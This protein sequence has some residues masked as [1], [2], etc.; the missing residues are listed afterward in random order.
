MLQPMLPGG[1]LSGGTV[2]GEAGIVSEKR[3]PIIMIGLGGHARVVAELIA[4]LELPLVGVCGPEPEKDFPEF[5]GLPRVADDELPQRFPAA[6][7]GLALGIGGGSRP[8]GRRDIHQRLSGL[9]YD[10]PVLCHPSAVLSRHLTLGD[11]TQVMAG[12]VLQPGVSTGANVILNTGSQVDHDCTIAAH[13]HIAPGA[14]LCGGVTIGEAA[15]IG[16][17][18]TL[19]PGVTVGDGAVVGAGVTV[20]RDVGNDQV[21]RDPRW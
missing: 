12:T 6:Q 7:H 21:I 11:G 19:L 3:N 8:A 17:G 18:A 1:F 13:V 20:T 5:A 14:V 16:A 15:F 10:F 4:C 2:K 9:G